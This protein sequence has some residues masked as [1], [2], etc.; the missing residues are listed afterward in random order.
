MKKIMALLTVLVIIL[1]CF[2]MCVTASESVPDISAEDGLLFNMGVTESLY[3][4]Q[5]TLSR[6][7]F[8]FWL[9]RLAGIDESAMIDK[10]CFE[11]VPLSNKYAGAVATV[12]E[13]GIM[14]GINNR[15]FGVKQN[16]ST[17]DATVALVR[18]LG[19]EVAAIS[20]GGY[21]GGYLKRASRI[22]L[23]KGISDVSGSEYC[24]ILLMCF[25]ALNI[26]YLDMYGDVVKSTLLED[27]HGIYES[28]G[29][30]TANIYT[31]LE[32]CDENAPV[33]KIQI[34]GD[35]YLTDD[36]SLADK[37]G[38]YVRFWY[39]DSTNSKDNRLVFACSEKNKNNIFVI[40]AEDIVDAKSNVVEYINEKDKPDT[41]KLQPGFSFIVNNRAVI[42]RKTEDVVIDDG[43]LILIDND[44][45]K[46]YEVVKARKPET[47]VFQGVDETEDI[48]YC[49]EGN[50]KTDP[51]DEEYFASYYV[52]DSTNGSISKITVDE[53]P[54]DSVLTIYRSADGKYLELYAC[55][56][57]ISG[58]LEEKGDETITI[59][60]VEYKLPLKTEA[61][62]LNLGAEVI[63]SADMFGRPVYLE[64]E[65]YFK[66]PVYAYFFDY[67]KATSLDE[68]ARIR[69][70]I[71]DEIRILTLEEKVRVDDGVEYNGNELDTCT[72]LFEGGKSIRQ[73]IRYRI[74]GKGLVTDIYTE[75][76]NTD[77]SIKKASDVNKNAE[78]AYY[79]WYKIYAGKYILPED[80]FFLVVPTVED[81]PE[82]IELYSTS[83]YFGDD[84]SSC[85]CEVYDVNE[86]MEAG[87]VIIYAQDPLKGKAT[88]TANTSVG[89]IEKITRG[90]F[91]NYVYLWNGNESVKYGLDKENVP[92]I[93]DF[94]FGDVVR[95]VLGKDGVVT[96]LDLVLD[97]G[98]TAENTPVPLYYQDGYD[99]HYFSRVFKKLDTH[100]VLV[101]NYNNPGF[102]DSVENRIVAPA[103]FSTCAV[104]DMTQKKIIKGTYSSMA[105]YFEDSDGASYAYTRLYKWNT[106][107]ELIIYKF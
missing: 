75:N 88:T 60:G 33:G 22:G 52:V 83:Y 98:T 31:G 53:I 90:E 19:Y 73:L 38:E 84:I 30:V 46:V 86:D 101:P 12:S 37:I 57:V 65:E 91:Y 56:N 106:A 47:M 28:E 36:I 1:N 61:D 41:I 7:E 79:Q 55:E 68:K 92:N 62:K 23:D 24:E 93:D 17:T 71:G 85:Y 51:F 100:Y 94:A 104:V 21:P 54:A 4:G 96:T 3:N 58:V 102:D 6:G 15:E 59:D 9:T 97:I 10:E 81:E 76:G 13:L 89:I 67:A 18:L 40:K 45:D 27:V 103:S 16:I 69:T 44:Y 29:I 14:N 66:E 95:Y 25:N 34:A 26:S 80:G 5:T 42:S 43:E 82:D 48:I 74:N 77:F 78:T 87:A 107:K 20:D 63:F 8:A 105:K 64:D 39:T 70:V 2:N 49:R 35:N 50:I 99:Y 32:D 72:V 11:D